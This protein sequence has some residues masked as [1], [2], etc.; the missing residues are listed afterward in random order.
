MRR[1]PV[2]V[3]RQMTDEQRNAYRELFRQQSDRIWNADR[4]VDWD[5]EP[6]IPDHKREAWLRLINV[7]Y[8]LEL[9][10]LDTIQIMMSKATHKLR[11]PNLN[12]YLAAQCQDEA[13]HVYALDR[14]MDVTDGHDRLTRLERGLIDR[15]GNMASLGFYRA[16]NWLTSTLFSENFAALFLQKAMELPDTDPL[17][18]DIFRLIL[19]DE[20]RHVNFLHT[21]LPGMID[22]LSGLGRAYIWQSQLLLIAAVSLGLRRVRTEAGDLG[23]DTEEFKSTLT[24]NLDAQFRD[25]GIDHFL[26][27]RTYRRI[28]NAF[29]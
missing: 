25:A 9:M 6:Q 14:Y 21:I 7:F 17:A 13:R 8:G 27:A 29:I 11:D 22:R 16:E 20:V 26:H 24:E 12:L 2:A 4:D 5:R 19:R 10:G 1:S 23:I 15:F 28:M 18:K 3:S